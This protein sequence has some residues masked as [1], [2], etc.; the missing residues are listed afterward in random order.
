MCEKIEILFFEK[1]N[2]HGHLASQ[3]YECA[4]G[5]TGRALVSG[6]VVPSSIPTW[7]TRCIHYCKYNFK[8]TKIYEIPGPKYRTGSG[9]LQ[10]ER[11]SLDWFPSDLFNIK[12]TIKLRSRYISYFSQTIFEVEAGMRNY[13]A[14]YNH[15]P[16]PCPKSWHAAGANISGSKC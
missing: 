1:F 12:W 8:M 15:V 14:K 13:G 5:L 9:K 4:N 7:C 2:R 10:I 11:M 16:D 6:T 3:W